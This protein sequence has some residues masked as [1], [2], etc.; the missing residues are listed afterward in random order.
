[1]DGERRRAC[2]AA[3]DQINPVAHWDRG[4]GPIVAG[5][6]GAPATTTRSRAGD[7]LHR[8][9][10]VDRER[11]R[12]VH[13]RS[14]SGTRALVTGGVGKVIVGWEDWRTIGGRLYAQLVH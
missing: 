11:R 5:W 13:G 3:N 2:T 8:H 10:R 14:T 9:G 12:R 7:R 1:M 4:V 6:T